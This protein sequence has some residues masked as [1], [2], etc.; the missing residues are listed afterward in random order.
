[1]TTETDDWEDIDLGDDVT[2]L[3]DEAEAGGIETCCQPHR[4]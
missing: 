4:G 2:V 1:M 3:D